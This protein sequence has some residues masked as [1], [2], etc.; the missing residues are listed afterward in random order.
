KKLGRQ[1]SPRVSSGVE[2]PR[3]PA[4]ATRSLDC[5]RDT[6]LLPGRSGLLQYAVKQGASSNQGGPAIRTA[7]VRIFGAGLTSGLKSAANRGR[8][9]GRLVEIE[10]NQAHEAQSVRGRGHAG[11]Q[12]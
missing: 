6:G 10:A 3:S 1:E 9:S 8:I 4:R 7:L 5:A 12:P 2:R 11:A